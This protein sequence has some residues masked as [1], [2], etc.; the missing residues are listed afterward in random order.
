MNESYT[1]IYI[2][3]AIHIHIHACVN[4]HMEKEENSFCLKSAIFIV[5]FDSI[6]NVIYELLCLIAGNIFIKI[7]SKSLDTLTFGTGHGV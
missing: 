2:Y 1:Y 3:K 5:Y 6:Q 4:W 7:E